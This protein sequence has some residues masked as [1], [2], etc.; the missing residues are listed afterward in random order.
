MMKQSTHVVKNLDLKSWSVSILT[1]MGRLMLSCPD[2][3]VLSNLD[4]LAGN[5][6]NIRRGRKRYNRWAPLSSPDSL[7][8]FTFSL[9][10]KPGPRLFNLR[11]GEKKNRLI[12]GYRLF[13]THPNPATSSPGLF[14]FLREKP[15]GRGCP[16]P[17]RLRVSFSA[18]KLWDGVFVK[19]TIFPSIEVAEKWDAIH[20][21]RH[22]MRYQLA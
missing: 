11:S 19:P 22:V 1:C 3:S 2:F 7:H 21:P 8:C 15:W 4:S 12:A 20:R 5:G 16:I 18:H 6:E 10:S 14:P 9:T 13:V 17:L